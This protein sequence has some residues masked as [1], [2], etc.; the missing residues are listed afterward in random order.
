VSTPRSRDEYR[1]WCLRKLGHPVVNI[2]V[3]DDQVE[4]AIDEALQ[5]FRDFHFDGVEHWYVSH[6][7]DATDIS[8]R[9]LEVD[10]DVIGVTRIFPVGSTNASVN[11]FDLRYQ[12]RL[13][14]LYD[15]TSTSYVN[16]VLTQQHIRTLDMMFTGEAPIRFNRHTHKLYIDWN[17]ESGAI[18]VGEWI[19]IEGRKILDM[20]AYTETWDD[21]MFKKLGTAH[22]K[23]QW[24]QNMKKYAGMQLPGAIAMNGQ[25]VFDEAVAEIEALELEIKNTYQEPPRFIIA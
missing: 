6:Q 23:K 17:W 9:Y 14:D 11:M 16:Y 25:V 15:F 5:F 1:D 22:I 12:L 8:N 7:V 18:Q 24:G 4:D 19:V 2:N 10:E 20:D 13:H 21:R 3:D